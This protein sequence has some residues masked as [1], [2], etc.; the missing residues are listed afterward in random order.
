MITLKL[1]PEQ[2]ESLEIALEEAMENCK[3]DDEY[4]YFAELLALV[5]TAQE[6]FYA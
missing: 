4:G 6:E 2:C 1:E 5:K 3:S